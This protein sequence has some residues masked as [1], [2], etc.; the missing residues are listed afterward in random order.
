MCHGQ[1]VI[2][3][4]IDGGYY[5]I[6]L[7]QP[8]DTLFQD[9]PWG[10]DAVLDATLKSS[11]ERGLELKQL[12]P[13]QDVDTWQDLQQVQSKIPALQEYLNDHGLLS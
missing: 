13:L 3:P 7:T 4:S 1:S 9:K 11:S 5:F 6:G 10:S 12:S 8:A 2:G